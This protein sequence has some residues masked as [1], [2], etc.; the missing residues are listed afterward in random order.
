MS[1]LVRLRTFDISNNAITPFGQNYLKMKFKRLSNFKVEDFLINKT[2]ET[3]LKLFQ[4]ST[5]IIYNILD[6]L[7]DAIT[8]F[9]NGN[10]DFYGILI[11]V[12]FYDTAE[13]KKIL[14]SLD[15][16]SLIKKT[17]IDS[18]EN[19]FKW[20][21]FRVYLS[22]E[23]ISLLCKQLKYVPE[24]TELSLHECSLNNNDIKL[25]SKSIQQ[26]PY[27]VKLDLS[28]NDF[29]D[30]GAEYLQDIFKVLKN[31]VSINISSNLITSE[32]LKGMSTSLGELTELKTLDISDNRIGWS[33]ISTLNKVLKGLPKFEKLYMKS[34]NILYYR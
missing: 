25:L 34:I 32:P 6:I 17:L 31:I 2:Q 5:G 1:S 24:L 22:G 10:E 29:G 19:D 4:T 15:K 11:S 21:F 28:N 16:T 20:P 33:G 30:A 23:G 12:C 13:K 9:K 18:I 27:I 3:T 26:T 7:N 8:E 14:R